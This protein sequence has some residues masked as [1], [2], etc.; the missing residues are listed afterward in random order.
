MMTWTL[1]TFIKQ[2]PGFKA[3]IRAKPIE[4]Q[5]KTIP[6]KDQH[7]TL[8]FYN[9]EFT[10]FSMEWFFVFM[11]TIFIWWINTS[12]YGRFFSILENGNRLLTYTTNSTTTKLV[13]LLK[14]SIWFNQIMGFRFKPRILNAFFSGF[15]IWICQQEKK[16]LL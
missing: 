10:L 4:M 11:W 15:W 9:A 3:S 8:N 7:L 5:G 14:L 2:D 1:T 16:T 12:S 6:N 13:S